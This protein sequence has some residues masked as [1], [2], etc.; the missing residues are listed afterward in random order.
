MN[1]I[2]YYTLKL[3]MQRII[4]V[5]NILIAFNSILVAFN[6]ILSWNMVQKNY[7]IFST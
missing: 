6:N 5:I 7:L 4:F 3:Y 2:L 1:I